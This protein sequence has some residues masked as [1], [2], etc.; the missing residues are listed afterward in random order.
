MHRRQ[1]TPLRRPRVHGTHQHSHLAGL[2]VGG[3]VTDGDVGAGAVAHH[4]CRAQREVIGAVHS[5]C[6]EVTPVQRQPA[7]VDLEGIVQQ[8]VGMVGAVVGLWCSCL[9]LHRR[10]HT[11]LGVAMHISITST[12]ARSNKKQQEARTQTQTNI[13]TASRCS[14]RDCNGSTTVPCISSCSSCCICVFC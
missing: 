1:R 9:F 11:H 2:E 12:V 8:S 5:V 13:C 7:T 6:G 3:H 4:H 10:W 14:L